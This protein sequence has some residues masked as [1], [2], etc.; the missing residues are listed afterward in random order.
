MKPDLCLPK[1]YPSSSK[2]YFLTKQSKKTFFANKLP[3]VSPLTK[4][5]VV[6]F[7]SLEKKVLLASED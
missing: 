7:I 3:S 2:K 6:G 1:N 5:N 4:K